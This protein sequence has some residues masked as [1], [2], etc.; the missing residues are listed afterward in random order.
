M[1]NKVEVIKTSAFQSCRNLE[2]L[3][4]SNSLRKIHSYAFSGSGLRNLVL[5]NSLIEI[6]DY[7]FHY[8]QKLELVRLP[9]KLQIMGE[10]IFDNSNKI[11]E[12]RLPS[13]I[14]SD[15]GRTFRG[16]SVPKIIIP[17]GTR[18]KFEMLL[19]IKDFYFPDIAKTYINRICEE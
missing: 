1:G 8:C 3:T 9:N 10:C 2:S 18:A 7:A 6:C 19:I 11:K 5:P 17:K 14:T 16:C 12:I 15:L 4:F 13:T